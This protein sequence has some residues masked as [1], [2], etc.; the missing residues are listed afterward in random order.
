MLQVGHVHTKWWCRGEIKKIV[1]NEMG[2]KKSQS[3][4][5]SRRFFIFLRQT[6]MMDLIRKIAFLWRLMSS[7]DT[8]RGLFIQKWNEE[9][10]SRW[11]RLCACALHAVDVQPSV[12]LYWIGLRPLFRKNLKKKKKKEKKGKRKEHES[13]RWDPFS[14]SEKEWHLEQRSQL[15]EHFCLRQAD[16]QRPSTPSQINRPRRVG[17]LRDDSFMHTQENRNTHTQ[18]VTYLHARLP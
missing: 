7:R 5:S 13:R 8:T 16:W 1:K 18:N 4:L 3:R 11:F 6:R 12:R 2:G 10:K 17:S 9:G 14:S 15:C